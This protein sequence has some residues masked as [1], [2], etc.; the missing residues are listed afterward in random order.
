VTERWFELETEA[1]AV[2]A[3][4]TCKRL[5]DQTSM[6]RQRARRQIERYMGA[7][8]DPT[9]WRMRYQLA[10][11]LPLVWNLTRS[12]V[13]T[14]E[15]R[16]GSASNPKLQFVTSDATWQVR[17]RGQKLDQFVDA[18]ALQDCGQYASVHDLRRVIL[19]DALIFGVGWAQVDADLE[20]GRV[21]T[22]RCFPW[23]VMVDS[24]D[25]RYGSP[26]QWVRTF[27]ASKTA[28]IALFGEHKDAIE[29]ASETSDIELEVELGLSSRTT[30]EL[31]DMVRC[32][33]I[34]RVACGPD[35][36]GRH[37]LLL[38]DGAI[39][40]IDEDW[41][42]EK[43]PLVGMWWDTPLI[44][45]ASQ[46][47][48]DE[49]SGIEDEMNRVLQRVQDCIRHTSMATILAPND[50]LVNEKDLEDTRDACVIK[51]QGQSQPTVFQALPFTSAHIQW[52]TLAYEKAHELTGVS[53]MSSTAQ[54]DPGVN[55]AVA[56][57]AVSKLQS[58]RF[59]SLSRQQE[60]FMVR[61]AQLAVN[62]VTLIAKSTKNF[63]VKWPG[64]GFL[65]SLDWKDI[66]LENDQYVMQI[67]PVGQSKNEPADRE[68][69]AEELLGAGLISQTT[70]MA[71]MSSTLDTRAGTDRQTQQEE[72]VSLYIDRWLDAT[73]E[74]L[75]SG[76]YNEDK[77]IR[78]VI[79]P[80]RWLNMP[81][82]ILQVAQG[83]MRAEIDEAPDEIRQLFLDWL[84]MAEGV[85]ESQ[86]AKKAA[87]ATAMQ[88]AAA[89]A[90]TSPGVAQAVMQGYHESPQ[91]QGAPPQAAAA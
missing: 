2:S 35:S 69:R 27:T 44:G 70:Y 46:S 51:T 53:E 23:E 52:I 83:Y 79:P 34:W 20:M 11:D 12:L 72:L 63:V 88:S 17:R 75:A 24:R 13:G 4:A 26:A 62:A 66:S 84:E 21:L 86:E 15:S 16:I 76:M 39:P 18:L 77:Q 54:K 71:I 40:L 80:L 14:V 48:A 55:S 50:S 85:L 49:L 29:L 89:M 37:M 81:D 91:P 87:A 6:Q 7:E 31:S 19:R 78:L 56:I 65:K 25:A 28:L 5:W 3:T 59:A 8:L 90:R 32:Y 61:W 38:E 43:P 30:P 73:D 57:R 41:L 33:H 47:L 68:Q 82:A 64:T 74:Q 67:R 9:L 42:F 60:N 45:I 10:E 1:A 22:E 58:V 36:P